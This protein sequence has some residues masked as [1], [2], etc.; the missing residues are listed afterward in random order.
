MLVALVLLGCSHNLDNCTAVQSESLF[1]KTVDACEISIAEA[2]NPNVNAP[3]SLSYCVQVDNA[4]DDPLSKLQ[5]QLANANVTL[6]N[7]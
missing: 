4:Q 7:T 2:S 1:F 6:R 3:V 5:V